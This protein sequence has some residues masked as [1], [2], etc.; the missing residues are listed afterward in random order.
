MASI[1]HDIYIVKQGGAIAI[2]VFFKKKKK[3][4]EVHFHSNSKK[5]ILY[6][7]RLC[8]LK[9]NLYL[10]YRYHLFKKSINKLIS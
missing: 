7:S 8:I 6:F 10:K 5:K 1:F 2:F 9:I 4:E 3:K